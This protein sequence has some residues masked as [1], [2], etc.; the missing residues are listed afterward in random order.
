MLL[1]ELSWLA[2]VVVMVAVDLKILIVMNFKFV[3][4]LQLSVLIM[5]FPLLNSPHSLL[6]AVSRL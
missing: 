1:L 4:I 5:G 6:L 2:P 3:K